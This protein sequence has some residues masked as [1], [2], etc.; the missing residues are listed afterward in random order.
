M[1]QYYRNAGEKDAREGKAAA[2]MR[3]AHWKAQQDYNAA[4]AAEKAKNK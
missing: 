3:N 2:D 1:S 4:Y